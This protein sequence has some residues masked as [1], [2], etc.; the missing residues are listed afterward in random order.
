VTAYHL[1]WEFETDEPRRAAFEEA[2]GPEG[3][4]VEFFR[5]GEGYLG[6]ELF[7]EAG[8]A[9]RYVTIDRWNSRGAY[10]AFR[11]RH[12]AQYA[13]LDARCEALTLRES[14]LGAGESAD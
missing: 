10:D 4:W 13:A 2:Y 8:G 11:L 5:G 6:T 1:V 14:F 9:C 7:R 12:A 3:V